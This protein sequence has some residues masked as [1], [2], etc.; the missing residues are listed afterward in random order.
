MFKKIKNAVSKKGTDQPT[1]RPTNRP[2]DMASYRVTSMRLKKGTRLSKQT[3]LDTSAIVVEVVGSI[4][5]ERLRPVA[6]RGRVLTH[7][8]RR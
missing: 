8:P 3:W 2:T 6:L 4:G 5:V 7:D 1:N